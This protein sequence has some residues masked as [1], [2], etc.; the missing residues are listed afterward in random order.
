MLAHVIHA[1]R[2]TV[3]GD[4]ENCGPAV[5]G[6]VRCAA[7]QEMLVAVRRHPFS[8]GQVAFES[9]TRAGG[10]SRGIDLKDD[11]RDLGPIGPFRIGVEKPEISDEVRLVVTR[12]TVGCGGSVGDFWGG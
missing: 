6:S 7:A 8:A 2:N 12:Q 9:L 4:A 5:F 11:P 3:S 10:L 1:F